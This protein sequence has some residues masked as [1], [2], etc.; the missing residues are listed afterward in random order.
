VGDA[1]RLR[2]LKLIAEQPRTTQELAPLV[3]IS[4][5]GLS[6]HLRA[7]A[8]AGVVETRRDGYYVLYSLVP[9]LL[10]PLSGALLSFLGPRG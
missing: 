5:A 7:L 4:E 8:N 6:K 2:A 9:E 1:T 3:G 10:E